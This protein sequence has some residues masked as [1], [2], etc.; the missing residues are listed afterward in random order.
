MHCMPVRRGDE[1]TA[2]AFS[3]DRSITLKAK[4]KAN[5]GPTHGHRQPRPR[6]GMK[7]APQTLA[8]PGS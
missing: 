4:A 5:L 3:D 2:A 6:P 8:S 1:V 7:R